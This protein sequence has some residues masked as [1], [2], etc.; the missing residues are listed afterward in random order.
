[1]RAYWLANALTLANIGLRSSAACSARWSASCQ[2]TCVGY[3][4]SLPIAPY[5]PLTGAIIIMVGI[6]RCHVRRPH[7]RHP[8]EHP[9]RGVL[10]DH[11]PGRLAMTKQG[12]RARRHQPPPALRRGSRHARHRRAGPAADLALHFGPPEY[13][14]WCCSMTAL[15]IAGCLIRRTMPAVGMARP[16]GTDPLTGTC[17]STS[18]HG[19]DE[20]LISCRCWD[21]PW[22]RG[23][24]EPGPEGRA[25][26][27]GQAGS[28]LSMIPRGANL[29]R[30][31]AAPA[32]NR[33]RLVLGCRGHAAGAHRHLAYDVE[34]HISR[35][36]EKFARA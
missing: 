5:L 6:Y 16:I 19:A 8:H 27:R 25:D 15:V 11:G 28:V 10:G 2:P 18:H 35:T 30:G 3:M 29:A 4:T 14:G 12:A 32:R 22:Y 26:L 7:H 20:G 13:F 23:A 17:G 21:L 1:M 9:R 33:H 31:L 24:G 36:P 34:R